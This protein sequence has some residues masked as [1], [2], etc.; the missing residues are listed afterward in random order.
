M[1]I[2]VGIIPISVI[3]M[4]NRGIDHYQS[5]D[6][7]RFLRMAYHILLHINGNIAAMDIVFTNG[8][9]SLMI[10]ALIKRGTI[11]LISDVRLSFKIIPIHSTSFFV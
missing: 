11:Y 3:V 2:L 1:M 10:G 8:F 5:L 4:V 6:T 9:K 7:N